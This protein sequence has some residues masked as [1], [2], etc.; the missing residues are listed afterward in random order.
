MSR[1][2]LLLV[3]LWPGPA[4]FAGPPEGPSSRM[5]PDPVPELRAEVQR[6]EREAARAPSDPSKAEDLCEARALLAAAEG[7]NGAAAAEWRKV[8]AY[9]D[10]LKRLSM[11]L[12]S[13]SPPAILEGP[14]AEARCRLAEVERDRA[15][16]AAELPKVIASYQAQLDR[17]QRLRE[18]SA[19][20]AEPTAEEK[21]TRRRLREARVRLDA[22]RL[23]SRPAPSPD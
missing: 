12:C 1:M 4:A 2:L 22:L 9:R 23:R 10:E 19:V 6:R 17:V 5:V 8:I 20:A 13:P 11:R 7:R 21:D 15:A 3:I 18:F 14:V 16:L